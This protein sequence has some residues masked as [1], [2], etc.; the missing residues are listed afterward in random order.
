MTRVAARW[1]TVMTLAVC[2]A[3]ACGGSGGS[4]EGGGPTTVTVTV[5][6]AASAGSH[7]DSTPSP[8]ST[9]EAPATTPDRLADRCGQGPACDDF[10]TPS[11]NIVCFASARQHG[12]VECEIKSGLVPSPP[13]DGCDL[14][15]P[16]L[17]LSSTGLAKP[18]CRSDPS[19]AWFDTQIP[20]LAYGT[21]WAGF[22]VACRSGTAGL[23]CTNRDNHGF[24]LSR[25]HWS[26]F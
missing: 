12:F 10:V 21:T 5:T 19:P 22:G 4:T 18:S 16:G 20:V 1:A 6:T 11:G 23:R 17:T 7:P 24:F 3:A 25:E 2:T 9:T 13:P 15:Q 8:V 14:E 26:T